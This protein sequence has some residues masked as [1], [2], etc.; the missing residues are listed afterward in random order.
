[1][2]SAGFRGRLVAPVTVTGFL[3]A[4]ASSEADTNTDWL[5]NIE[6]SRHPEVIA[7]I[8]LQSLF[9]A[10]SFLQ[11]L[12]LLARRGFPY[13]RGLKLTCVSVRETTA[14]NAVC[15]MRWRALQILHEVH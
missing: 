15:K 1:M 4:H 8:S 11:G 6:V 7:R 13:S 10:F 12:R 5:F 9:H 2:R 14:F 3:A